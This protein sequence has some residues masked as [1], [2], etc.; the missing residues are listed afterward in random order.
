MD[1]A[2]TVHLPTLQSRS[3]VIFDF[4]IRIITN[5]IKKKHKKYITYI[6]HVL[7]SVS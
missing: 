1:R 6:N 5:K 7:S 3:I 2:K 4:K